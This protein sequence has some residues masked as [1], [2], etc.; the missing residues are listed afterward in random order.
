MSITMSAADLP[1][2]G[3]DAGRYVKTNQVE[4][5][6]SFRA[7]FVSWRKEQTPTVDE[8]QALPGPTRVTSHDIID[9]R[10][11]SFAIF[12]WRKQPETDGRFLFPLFDLSSP[13]RPC[14]QFYLSSRRNDDCNPP[15]CSSPTAKEPS[16]RFGYS[17][18]Q[19][20][21]HYFVPTVHRDQDRHRETFRRGDFSNGSV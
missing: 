5:W 8:S 18:P 16:S 1:S 11:S 10:G 7:L 2:D 12:S 6:A 21:G 19:R 4:A 3:A 20:F 17:I 13:K 14:S 15:S 9:I